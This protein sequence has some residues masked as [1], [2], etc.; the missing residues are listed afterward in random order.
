MRPT[1]D[2]SWPPPNY[3]LSWLVSSP[4]DAIDLAIQFPKIY[5]IGTH[6]IISQALYLDSLGSG[7]E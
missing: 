4:N 6:D 5:Y 1:A 3:W 2:Y 7:V